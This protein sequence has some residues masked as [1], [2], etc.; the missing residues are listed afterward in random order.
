[1]LCGQKLRLSLMVPM[2]LPSEIISQGGRRQTMKGFSYQKIR[3]LDYFWTHQASN[4]E[5]SFSL[6][7]LGEPW[8][9]FKTLV[10]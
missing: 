3:N 5:K 7:L 6:I 1:M 8:M 4:V 10:T 2:P 9:I